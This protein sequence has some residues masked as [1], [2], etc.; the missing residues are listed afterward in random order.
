MQSVTAGKIICAAHG[1]QRRALHLIFGRKNS[2][3][4]RQCAGKRYV[5][6]FISRGSASIENAASCG[7]VAKSAVCG[8]AGPQRRHGAAGRELFQ[9]QP[10]REHQADTPRRG[11]NGIA[12][13][14]MRR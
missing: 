8:E 4:A 3:F 6:Q 9:E 2:R 7:Y 11:T 14:A 5:F 10:A 12:R 1:F 13:S